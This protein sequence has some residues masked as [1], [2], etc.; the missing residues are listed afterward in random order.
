MPVPSF[1]RIMIPVAISL[2]CAV[3]DAQSG[4]QPATEECDSIGTWY[5]SVSVGAG[6]LTNPL[7]SGTS[8]PLIVIPH[9]SYRGKRL[10]V[11]DLEVG[12]T[13]SESTRHS[14]S[15]IASPGYD[16]AFFY[17][18]DLQNVFVGADINGA[19]V[20][21]GLTP[22]QKP[23]VTVFAGPEWTF[24]YEG[25]A[26]QLNWLYDVTGRSGGSEIRAA[27]RAPLLETHGLLY[28]SSGF[29]WKSA[30][31]VNYYYGVATQYSP[32]SSL[33]PFVKLG[34]SLPLSPRWRFTA[35]ARYERLSRA[36]SDSPIVSDQYAAAVFAGCTYAF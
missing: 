16:R 19:A 22:T 26:G 33:D 30:A 14:F 35:F 28:I 17:R 13:L 20:P 27:L 5:F 1:L 2:S 32:G 23:K 10:F 6:F 29:T 18:E 34:Y 12:V 36:I 7:A 15:L 24:Q 25:I 31:V 4:C 3:A 11:D 9:V 8:I 21:Y